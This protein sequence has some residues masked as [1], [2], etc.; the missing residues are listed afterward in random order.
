MQNDR[1]ISQ[2][3]IK[4]YLTPKQCAAQYAVDVDGTVVID[5]DNETVPAVVP[6]LPSTPLP[7]QRP[8]IKSSR[9][10]GA[11]STAAPLTSRRRLDNDDP[12]P[13][14]A[15]VAPSTRRRRIIDD[16]DDD[17][18]VT[19]PNLA[20]QPPRDAHIVRNVSCCDVV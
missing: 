15:V 7:R 17:V 12:P 4:E 9:D 5:S 10:D 8:A 6:S 20:A 14:V 3:S 11:A 13:E 18:V 1:P 2:R 16:D 19:S